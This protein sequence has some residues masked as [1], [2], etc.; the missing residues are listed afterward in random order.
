M[1]P[2]TTGSG[3]AEMPTASSAVGGLTCVAIVTEFGR[4]VAVNG[5]RGTDHGTGGAAFLVGGAVNGGRIV[6][7]WPGLGQRDL[8]QNRD[9]RPMTDLRGVC[10]GVLSQRFGLGEAVLAR[11]VFPGSDGVHPIERLTA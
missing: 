7:E 5:T 2:S 8:Y 3:A 1:P 9:L 10:K 6:G 11:A 4:T